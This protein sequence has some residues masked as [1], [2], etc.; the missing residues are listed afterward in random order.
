MHDN[1]F[2]D[3]PGVSFLVMFFHTAAIILIAVS[4][5]CNASYHYKNL[6][7]HLP[8]DDGSMLDVRC[9]SYVKH[10]IS[11]VSST[12][13]PHPQ[14]TVI[15]DERTFVVSADRILL[16]G[17]LYAPLSRGIKEIR[18][19][20]NQDGFKVMA[21]GQAVARSALQPEVSP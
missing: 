1:T 7:S 2:S 5:G 4:A 14:V 21:D 8:R 3:L 13:Q 17:E 19:E 6:A 18:I 12:L 10:A 11:S 9:E 15:A 16:N 20:I